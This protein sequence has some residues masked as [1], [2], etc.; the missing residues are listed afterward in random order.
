[1]HSFTNAVEHYFFYLYQI[2]MGCGI[3]NMT[4]RG[5]TVREETGRR[6]TSFGAEEADFFC[7]S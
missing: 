2:A 4:E 3:T 5:S 7:I 1:M 6:R